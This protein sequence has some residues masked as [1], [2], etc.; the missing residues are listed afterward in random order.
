MFGL[1]TVVTWCLSDPDVGEGSTLRGR[2]GGASVSDTLA[3]ASAKEAWWAAA[4]WLQQA[5][6]LASRLTWRF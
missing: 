1:S 4:R 6:V 3:T 5:L 2:K